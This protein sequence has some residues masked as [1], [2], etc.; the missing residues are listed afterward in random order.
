MAG[1]LG[2][3]LNA[4]VLFTHNATIGLNLALFGYLQGGETVY[5]S[6]LEH[7]ATMRP[8]HALAQHRGVDL[9]ILPSHADGSIHVERLG[10]V[11]AQHPKLLVVN[12]VSNV[13]G[14]IQPLCEIHKRIPDAVLLIDASQSLGAVSVRADEWKLD[15]LAWT[16]HKSLLGPTGV[17]GLFLRDPEQCTPLIY[18]GTG[19]RSKEFAMPEFPPDR[20]EAGTPN[21]AGL[22]GLAAAIEHVPGCAHSNADWLEFIGM[23]RSIPGIRILAAM[24]S[25]KQ[26]KVVSVS[27]DTLS[28]SE[29]GDALWHGHG[30]AVRVGLHCAPLA[31]R[32]LGTFPAG[33]LRFSPSVF[34]ERSDFDFVFR[35]LSEVCRQ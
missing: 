29:I 15:A 30:I 4:N 16:G 7:N 28:V 22:I 17:G 25:T 35:A 5:T 19:S 12:H 27:H 13:N 24:D 31:H 1:M 26:G 23:L 3:T 8:L 2:T 10:E 9:R 21:I 14:V 18:G 11:A 34:H 6:A 33:T 20:F 32:T